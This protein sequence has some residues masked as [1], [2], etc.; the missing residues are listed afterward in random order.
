MKRKIDIIEVGPRDGF[1]NLKEYIPAA[2]KK[3]FIE[4]L[5]E[6]GVTH[7]QIT[8]FVSPKAIPQMKDASEIGE[9]FTGKYPEL[10][11]FAL[12][13]NYRGA[14]NAKNAGFKK[15]TN[16]ISLS[17]SH[18]KANINRTHDESFAELKKIVEELPELD[19]CLDIATAFGCPFEGE[20]S[21]T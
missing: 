1:Q 13:P 6:S 9:Y 10:D 20:R 4:D 5:I 14:A 2:Q 11:L 7:M 16:V 21:S 3:E 18:N 12:V 8:S 17:A 15:V 19:V